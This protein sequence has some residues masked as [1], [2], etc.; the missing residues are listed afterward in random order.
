[1]SGL[2]ITSLLVAGALLVPLAYL[3]LPFVCFRLERSKQRARL[4]RARHVACLTFDDGPDPDSTPE[5]LRALESRGVHATFFVLGQRAERH[6]E[7]IEAIRAAGHEIAE[8]GFAHLHPWWSSPWRYARD[9]AK[10]GRALDRLGVPAAGRSY[11][12]A[13][14][15]GNL[16]TLGYMCTKGK[17]PTFW[18]V[19][20]RDYL[21]TS[22]ECI[23]RD[24]VELVD[25]MTGAVI[26]LLHDGRTGRRAGEEAMTARAVEGICDSL[27]ERG[28]D[29]MTVRETLGGSRLASHG[30]SQGG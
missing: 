10:G 23:A 22:S 26:I 14:G 17:R 3:V 8:H 24:T 11:R 12:P 6:P 15:K 28:F 25:R 1:M 21:Q 18:N 30:P 4:A 2:T 9:L 20:P 5:V 13:F 27:S 7:Q 19:D 29:F 16:A